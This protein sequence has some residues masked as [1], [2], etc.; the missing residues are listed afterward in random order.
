MLKTGTLSSSRHY[1]VLE[2]KY[3][4]LDARVGEAKVS[5][6]SRSPRPKHRFGFRGNRAS[7]RPQNATTDELLDSLTRHAELME[8]DG[9]ER[10]IE[11]QTI[12][13]FEPDNETTQSSPLELSRT[14]EH[15]R[16]RRI[17][18]SVFAFMLLGGVAF[19]WTYSQLRKP[20][21]LQDVT[22]A[23]R[24]I[25]MVGF[26][27]WYNVLLIALSALIFALLAHR[28]RTGVRTRSLSTT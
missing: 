13:E 25:T 23:Q 26:A 3:S 24:T 15:F 9:K 5:S 27:N 4:P 12:L 19:L 22:I 17:G 20:F 1:A 28:S 16:T 7:P 21:N 10:A 18:R 14:L 2:R 6:S 11:L 8:K